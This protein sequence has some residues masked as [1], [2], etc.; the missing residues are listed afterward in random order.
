MSGSRSRPAT[1]RLSGLFTDLYELT[2]AQAF[3]AEGMRGEAVFEVF[4]R[5]LPRSRRY[6]V[7]AGLDDVL[8]FL[9]DLTFDRDEVD[10]VRQLGGFGPAFLDA[11]AGLRFTGEV[12]AVPEGTVVFPGEPLVQVVAPIAEAQ[13]AETAVINQIHLQTVLASKAARVVCAAAGRPVIDFGARRAHGVDAALKLARVSYLA[14]AAGTSNVLASRRYGIPAVGTMA[15]SFVQAF[16]RE[17]DALAAFTRI[18]P[19][20]TLLIDTYDTLAG[21]D[22]VIAL[23]QRLGEQFRVGGVRLDS[24]D[25]AALARAVRARLDA[26][27]LSGVRIIASSGLDELA[28]QRLVADGAPIDG[29]GVGTTMAVSHDAP[30][31][32]MAYKLVE[33]QGRGRTKRS[34]GKV[35]VPGRKQVLRRIER[36]RMVGDAVVRFGDQGVAGG[37]VPLLEQVMAGG[38]RTER[39]ALPLDQARAR[40][41]AQMALLP[42]E[43]LRLEPAAEATGGYPVEICRR[44]PVRHVCP[45]AICQCLMQSMRH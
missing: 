11:L 37:G 18:Y 3:L 43:L 29:F 44:C 22:Q 28:I 20:T 2:M 9:E 35:I 10:A 32:D 31:L 23:S 4:F 33:Y 17:A 38:R 45:E 36:G 40:W 12:W 13:L 14:G 7:A 6:A 24:G 30:D 42:D 8:E 15:H 41:A 16:D 1:P 19:D 39:G 34:P 21:A 27:G 5:R 26:A 25:L